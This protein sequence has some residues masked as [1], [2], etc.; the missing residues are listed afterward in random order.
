MD[1]LDTI[2]LGAGALAIVV[3]WW[4]ICVPVALSLLFAWGV[5]KLIDANTVWFSY[6]LLAL[7]FAGGIGWHLYAKRQSRRS[8]SREQPGT[9]GGDAL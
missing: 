6:L 2:A 1:T 9:G 7:S 3:G 4:R 8:V 5:S